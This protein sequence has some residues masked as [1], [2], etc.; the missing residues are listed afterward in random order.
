LQI[1][2]IPNAPIVVSDYAHATRS[3]TNYSN[4]PGAVFDDES[5]VSRIN[6]DYYLSGDHK[7]TK[8][9]NVKYVAGGTL[10]QNRTKDV[11]VGGNNLVVPQLYNV[12]VRSGD[13]FIPTFGGTTTNLPIYGNST[14]GPIL[15]SFNYDILSRLVSVY[16][17][18]GFS[19]KGWANVEFTGRNDW[20]SRLNEAK[21]LLSS[22]LQLMLQLFFQMLSPL[23]RAVLF[24]I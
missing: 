11:G 15:G 14:L 2:K 19:Y 24:L 23:Y 7:I 20:D 22:I 4:Q 5:Y 3:P 17:S 16:G 9:I 8:D 6:L 13:A 18:V 12:A 1:L 21:P 10:R